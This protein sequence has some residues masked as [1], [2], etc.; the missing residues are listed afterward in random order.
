[1]ALD[2]NGY[3]QLDLPTALMQ[4][5]GDLQSNFSPNID[6]SD[7]AFFGQM[8]RTLA[9]MLIENDEKAESVYDAGFI[10]FSDGVSL[11]RVASNY[12]LVRKQAKAAEV[13]LSFIGAANYVITDGTVFMDSLGNE[14]YTLEPVQLD[15]N[16]AGSTTAVSNELGDA[17][18]VAANSI[19]NAQ[20]P[21]EEIETVNNPADAAGGQDMEADY[22]FR[23]R[24]MQAALANDSATHNGLIT[25]ML[26]VDGVTAVKIVENDTMETD[27]AGNPAKTIHFYVNGG[28]DEDVGTAIF[29]RIAAG[30]ATY[31]GKSSV[32]SDVAGNDHTVYFDRPVQLPV[33]AS[34]SV[35]AT[36][37]F[38]QTDG[39]D[40]IKTAIE[41]YVESLTMGEDVIYNQFFSNL[42]ALDGIVSVT[43]NIG[44]AAD[45]LGMNNLKV[46][47]YQLPIINDDNIEVTF[48]ES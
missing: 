23:K 20:L 35:N 41:G 10:G 37:D 33:Y 44:T 22:D 14:F 32:V 48:N 7:G 31:G 16:G 34:V 18:N 43:L 3:S 6:L 40:D 15:I 1:M 2:E 9:Q 17:F 4:V 19:Q 42:Y 11:D 36:S 39:I 45:T 24:V 29:N 26:N 5:R 21:V 47:D 38:N 13:T 27:T 25:A 8:A 46:S 30:V 28:T 12:G